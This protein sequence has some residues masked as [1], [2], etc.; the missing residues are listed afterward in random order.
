[1]SDYGEDLDLLCF[2]L[3]I[4]FNPFPQNKS[5][6]EIILQGDKMELKFLLLG[7]E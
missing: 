1:M 2:N 7:N 5:K 4:S 3:I 6:L